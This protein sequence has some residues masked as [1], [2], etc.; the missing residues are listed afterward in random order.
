MSFRSIVQLA[1]APARIIFHPNLSLPRACPDL[2]RTCR[3]GVVDANQSAVKSGRLLC[4]PGR[5]GVPMKA[6]KEGEHAASTQDH[7]FVTTIWIG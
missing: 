2:T 6:D 3:Q 7:S 4:L 1:R 5:G